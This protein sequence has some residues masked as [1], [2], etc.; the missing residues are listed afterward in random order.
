MTV[1]AARVSATGTLVSTPCLL[2]GLHFMHGATAGTV[3]LKD[4]GASGTSRAVV[5]TPAVVGSG[6]VPF[7]GGGLQFNTDLHATLTNVTGVTA[8]YEGA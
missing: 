5:D 1:K 7:A 4:G 3:E 8:V 2:L 6:F